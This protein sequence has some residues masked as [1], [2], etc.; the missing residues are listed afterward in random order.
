[1][2]NAFRDLAAH[3]RTRC[4]VGI[5]IGGTFTDLVLETGERRIT[6][7]LLTTPQAPERGVL[8]GLAALLAKADVA[9]GSLD[10]V[11]HGTTLAT[12]ALLERRGARTALLTTEGFRDVIEMGT[13]SRCDQYDLMLRKADPLVPRSLRFAVTERMSAHGDVLLPLDRPM[14]QAQARQ[15]GES[16]T[17]SLAIGFLHS[18]VNPAHEQQAAEIIARMLPSLD[19]SLSSDVSPEMREFERFSTT[20]VNAYVRPLI[21]G[22]LDRLRAGL[23]A[24]GVR[25]PL[26]M[27]LSNGGLC[28]VATA[29]RY[30]VRLLESGPAGGALLAARLAREHG[31]DQVLSV[32]IGGTTAKLCFIDGGEPQTARSLEVSLFYR[33]KAGSGIPL[34]IPVIELS[35]IGAGGGSIARVDDLGRVA[36][37]PESA[38]AQPGPVCYGLGGKRVTLTDVHLHAGRLSPEYFAAGTIA[39]DAATASRAL[40]A[41]IAQPLRIDTDEAAY[42]VA[43]IADEAMAQAVREHAVDTGRGVAGRTL[44]AFGGSAPLHAARL[45]DKLQIDRVLIPAQA[46]V[47]SALG[48]LHAALAF[49]TTQSLHQDLERFDASAVNALLAELT[50]RGRAALGALDPDMPSS[51]TMHAFVRYKGQGHELR[52]PLADVPFDEDGGRRLSAAFVNEYVKRYGRSIEGAGV[53]A[54]GWTVTVTGHEAPPATRGARRAQDA[55]ATVVSSRIVETRKVLDQA[56]RQRAD[57]AV[58]ARNALAMDVSLTGPMIVVDE[59][60]TIVV[61]PAFEIRVLHNADILLERRPL[62]SSIEV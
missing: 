28:D 19:I 24:L 35:E 59:E 40:D 42:A 56:S 20:C 46:G 8:D 53:E 4:R 25:A 54:L 62:A 27:M 32:D 9:P 12:N 14:L 11:M 21:R 57:F 15:I 49:E 31:L 3:R 23:D 52:V 6:H 51:T 10:A 5:D 44:I 58:V 7:K 48:F 2:R 17:R 22:Y 50:A 29:C 37:G 38:G 1:M 60:T 36:V 41:Q 16:G 39:L 33:F 47:G 30:P 45:A 26:L 55:P 34:R 61:P 18:Y 13:E 43:E